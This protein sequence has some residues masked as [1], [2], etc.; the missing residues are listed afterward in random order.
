MAHDKNY[1]V[2]KR[3][4]V[5]N[6]FQQKVQRRLLN[7]IEEYFQDRVEDENKLGELNQLLGEIEKKEKTKKDEG[8]PTNNQGQGAEQKK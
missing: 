4:E 5:V 6:H 8:N 7:A 3:Q 1:Y 2:G